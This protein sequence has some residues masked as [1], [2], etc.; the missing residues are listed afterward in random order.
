MISK[1]FFLTHCSDAM[2]RRL[3]V[4]VRISQRDTYIPLRHDEALL[5]RNN[6][7]LKH[8]RF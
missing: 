6:R 4:T 8:R 7:E 3:L 2:K 5:E 1:K